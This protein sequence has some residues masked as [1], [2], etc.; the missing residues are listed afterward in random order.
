M[1]PQAC[2]LFSGDFEA[3]RRVIRGLIDN[4]IKYT[5]EGGHIAISA[6]RN[7]TDARNQRQR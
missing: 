2:L 3:L 7:Q 5:P 4:A 6:Q 1:F